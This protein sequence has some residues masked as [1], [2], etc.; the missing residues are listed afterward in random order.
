MLWP[1]ETSRLALVKD[2]I[3]MYE[4]CSEY[5]TSGLIPLLGGLLGKSA[6]PLE[7]QNLVLSL[8]DM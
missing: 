6:M 3:Y 8:H 4:G 7:R 1:S 2:T 5:F